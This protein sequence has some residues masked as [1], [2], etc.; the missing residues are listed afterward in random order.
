ML[1]LKG[2]LI[3]LVLILTP[4]LIGNI[5]AA[6]TKTKEK[7]FFDN[8]VFQYVFGNITMWALYEII[9][10]P[11]ILSKRS[12]MLSVYIWSAVI[13]ALIICDCVY[14]VRHEHIRHINSKKSGYH[15]LNKNSWFTFFTAFLAVIMIAFQC[16]QYVFN[17]HL[18]EDDAR[19]IVN[20]CESYDNNSMLLIN[21]T[22]GEY[23]GT[24][25]GEL[26]KD[27][28]SPWVIYIAVISKLVK[29]YPTIAAHTILPVFLL[30][31]MYGIYWLIA[32][33]LFNENDY[34]PAWLFMLFA[35]LINM[36]FHA[37]VYTG[38]TFALTRIWQGKAV[39]AGLVI[40]ACFYLCFRIYKRDWN[41]RQYL[42]LLEI[43]LSACLL[44]GSGNI[45]TAFMTVVYGGY[46]LIVRRKL[47]EVFLIL[48]VCIPNVIFAL[49][50]YF[51]K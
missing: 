35:A 31:M 50:Y 40:P 51:I 15:F 1:I 23:E 48:S 24:W 16:Y 12:F 46:Y 44:S 45:I 30:L 9:A 3:F 14:L 2:L 17:M 27:V 7:T 5:I 13:L 36:F 41:L 38:S 28:T 4:L 37:S 47:K 20:A 25:I 43:N 10:V 6:F 33:K 39:V 22:T 34:Q 19:F 11:L 49:I 21:P 26:A 32:R 18:D 8:F 29:I 42:L